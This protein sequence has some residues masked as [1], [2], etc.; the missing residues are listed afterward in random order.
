MQA[1]INSQCRDPCSDRATQCGTNA[2]CT[3]AAHR[4]V[5]SCPAGLEGDPTKHCRHPTTQCTLDRECGPGA[6]C[7]GGICAVSCEDSSQVW[8]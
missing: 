2:L 6:G 3:V 8:I 1:C 5:C 4:A 7:V